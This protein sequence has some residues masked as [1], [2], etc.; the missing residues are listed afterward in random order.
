MQHLTASLA[1]SLQT[2]LM[3][4]PQSKL[5]QISLTPE[6]KEV[7]EKISKMIDRIKDSIEN[8]FCTI[9]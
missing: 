5:T 4:L 2:S 6:M 3:L 7:S 1:S 8:E 9:N